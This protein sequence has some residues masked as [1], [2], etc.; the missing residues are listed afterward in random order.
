MKI[1]FL[2]LILFFLFIN[3]IISGQKITPPKTNSFIGTYSGLDENA[4]FEFI[5]DSGKIYTFQDVGKEVIY[6]LYEEQ[7]FEKKFEVEWIS[8]IVEILDDEGELTG[9]MEKI[10]VIISLKE[11]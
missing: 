4:E 3:S 2:L 1:R 7:L 8:Q 10:A 11:L 5:A 6:D 9:E